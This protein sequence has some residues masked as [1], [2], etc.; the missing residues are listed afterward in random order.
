MM[1][2]FPPQA[3]FK[4]LLIILPASPEEHFVSLLHR[5]PTAIHT[6]AACKQAVHPGDMRAASE[7][8]PALSLAPA[9]MYH[10]EHLPRKGSHAP[11]C[12]CMHRMIW[13][14]RTREP[15]LVN[16]L[17]EQTEIRGYHLMFVVDYSFF[18]VADCGSQRER[19]EATV[20]ECAMA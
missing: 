1:L 15:N 17:T 3:R 6:C 10:V 16:K 20:G 2:K 7:L 11:L 19:D 18:N 14:V 12:K 8:M 5:H 4:F 13:Q 9:H